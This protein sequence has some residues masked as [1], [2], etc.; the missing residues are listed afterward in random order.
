LKN[1]TDE[2]VEK[3]KGVTYLA[4][5]NLELTGKADKM[6][7]SR[8]NVVNPDEVVREFG[9]DSLRLF[10]MFMGPLEATKPWSTQGVKGVYRFLDRVWRLFIDDRAEEVKLAA[11]V[12]DVEPDRDTLRLLHQT[13]QRVTEDLE[14]MRFNT[15]IAAMMELTNHLTGLEQRPRKVLETLVLLLSPFAPHLAEELWRALG[16]KASLAYEPWPQYDVALTREDTI[17]VPVQVNGKLRSKVTVPA[18][19]D[20]AALESAARADERIRSLIEG[21]QVRKVIVVPKKLV[22]IVVAG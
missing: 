13:I 11:A 6:S 2:Q 7:K 1:L 9:A 10:E 8:G 15:A 17:E 18:D 14:G 5:A 19:A 12:G 20:Q 22:N 21:K 4:G 3:R 16:H